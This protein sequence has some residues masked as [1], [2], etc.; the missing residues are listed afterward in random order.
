LLITLLVSQSLSLYLSKITE[1]LVGLKLTLT[2]PFS[3]LLGCEPLPVAPLAYQLPRCRGSQLKMPTGHLQLNKNDPWKR[4]DLKYQ[5]GK[6]WPLFDSKKSGISATNHS[7]A[8]KVG[9]L[10]RNLKA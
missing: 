9:T 3:S 7:E 5:S 1:S 6:L 8:L 2:T 4:I 10:I